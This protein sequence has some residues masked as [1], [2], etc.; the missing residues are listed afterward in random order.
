M[1]WRS[2]ALSL[3]DPFMGFAVDDLFDRKCD[4]L[5]LDHLLHSQFHPDR[6]LLKSKKL[7]VGKTDV[8][9]DNH[10]FP[11]VKSGPQRYLVIRGVPNAQGVP[12]R[13]SFPH[14]PHL[15]SLY[16]FSQKGPWIGSLSLLLCDLIT[17]SV[18]FAPHQPQSS[19][20]CLTG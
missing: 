7:L 2:P 9:G 16:C 4:H 18:N 12:T 1:S 15:P 5:P 20:K 6:S 3:F 19:Q 13:P 17:V 8:G 10:S 14:T 11:L